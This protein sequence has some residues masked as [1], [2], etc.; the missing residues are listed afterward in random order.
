MHLKIQMKYLNWPIPNYIHIP[1][2]HGNDGTKLSK[3]NGSMDVLEYKKI[4]L[5]YCF[6]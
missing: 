5:T 3:R 2:I 6:K 4:G 1:L